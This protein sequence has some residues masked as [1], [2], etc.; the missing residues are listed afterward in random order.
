VDRHG[1]HG[2]ERDEMGMMG[3]CAAFGPLLEAYYHHALEPHAAQS[4]A[5]HA[6]GCDACGA[7]LERF[8]ATDRLI[9]SA[10]MPT[11][12]PELRERLAARIATARTHRSAELRPSAPIK[13]ETVVDDMNGINDANDMD[14][15]PD[16]RWTGANAQT[17]PPRRGS[18]RVR[19]LLGS[20]AAVLVVAL[21]AGTLLTRMHGTPS[22]TTG[23]LG[24]FSPPKGACAPE[25][26]KAHLPANS[27][28]S[29][30]AMV[31]PDEGWAVGSIGPIGLND[32]PS[33]ISTLILHFH[34][35][36]WEPVSTSFPKAWLSSVSM[37]SATDGWAIGT[38]NSNSPL[39]LHYVNGVWKQVTL[40]G[41]GALNGIY[42]S[43]HMLSA[44]EGW[45]VIAHSKNSQGFMSYGLLHLFNGQWSEVAIPVPGV[46]DVLPVAPNEVWVA[47][48]A[49]NIQEDPVLYHYQAGTWTKAV[50]PTGVQIDHLRMVSPNDIWA[51]GHI[52]AENNDP[53]TQTASVL[54]YDGNGWRQA[55][56]DTSG[57][58][59]IVEAFDSVTSW[60]FTMQRSRTPDG[61]GYAVGSAQYHLDGKWY[62]VQ[63]PLTTFGDSR[64]TGG[65]SSAG[66]NVP[67]AQGIETL[68]RVEKDTYWTIGYIEKTKAN[69]SGGGKTIYAAAVLL[70]FA[71]GVWHTYGQ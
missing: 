55:P 25:D 29:S 30:L 35:C 40:P 66:W 2:A 51:S 56:V 34:N 63:W 21:L 70:Y 64:A 52:N 49:S 31:S 33:G 10:P 48:S 47:G 9:A 38:T 7:A 37:G 46:E 1:G 44:D 16:S 58:P 62:P 15:R 24:N 18:Q 23:G 42:T 67:G 60:A 69:P 20:A 36:V 59:Q 54:H 11:P 14:T 13:R 53:V 61:S 6:A 28:F 50:L 32:D 71:N 57:K 12:G 8:D 39:V 27:G 41:E 5:E 26:I 43:V 19:V 3:G 45:I 65:G 4:V 68:T 17:T 22:Q